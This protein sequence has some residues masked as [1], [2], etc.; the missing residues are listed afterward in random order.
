MLIDL[1]LGIVWKRAYGSYRMFAF[2][3]DGNYYWE[4]PLRLD[5]MFH[6]AEMRF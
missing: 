2:L 1:R 4:L 3:S 5:V 6:A